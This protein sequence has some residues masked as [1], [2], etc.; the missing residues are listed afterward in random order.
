MI[1]NERT[2]EDLFIL[3]MVSY[4][5]PPKKTTGRGLCLRGKC[6]LSSYTAQ[7]VND[8]LGEI[9][10]M[11]QQARLLLVSQSQETLRKQLT[12]KIKELKRLAQD[13]RKEVQSKKNKN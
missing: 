1:D 3:P 12:N 13:I 5:I 7:Q 2:A 10:E 4:S 6:F 9:E 11:I 8:K